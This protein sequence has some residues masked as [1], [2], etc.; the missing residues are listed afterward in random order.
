MALFDSVKQFASRSVSNVV[1]KQ[2]GST[3]DLLNPAN[4]RRAISGLFPG[5]GNGLGKAE[6]NIGF[7]NGSESG[8]AS[9]AN[10]NDWRVRISLADNSQLFYKNSGTTN[11]Q[12]Q[13][14][15][16]LSE[17]NGVI[18]PYLPTI[19][20][21]HTA[22]YTS[23]PLTHSNYPAVS[24][25]GSEVADITISGEFTVQSAEEGQY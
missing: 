14:M 3:F 13:I 19:T 22:G 2:L 11:T 23:T 17:T 25:N 16:P 15:L 10:E 9:A 24:Y 18:W 1:R 20:V 6:P 5:G 8:G 4:A 12:N 21:S 7:N